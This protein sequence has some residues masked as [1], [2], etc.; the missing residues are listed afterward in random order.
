MILTF[1]IDQNSIYFNHDRA[2]SI[3]DNCTNLHE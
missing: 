2:S 1:M 3:A